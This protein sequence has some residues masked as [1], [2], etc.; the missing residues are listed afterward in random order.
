M[1]LRINR[2]EKD[3]PPIVNKSKCVGCMNCA[4]ICPSDVFGLQKKG[5]PFPQIRFPEEC[6]HCNACVRECPKQA[7]TLRI[8]LPMSMVYMDASKVKWPDSGKQS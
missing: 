8:P 2:E 7:I 3:M 5:D 1:K 4:Q 6:W